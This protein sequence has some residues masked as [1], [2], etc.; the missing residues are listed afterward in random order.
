MTSL[1]LNRELESVRRE[2][3]NWKT[4][5]HENTAGT[6]GD[7]TFAVETLIHERAGHATVDSMC[8]TPVKVRGTSRHPRRAVSEAANFDFAVVKNSQRHSAVKIFLVAG[9]RGEMFARAARRKGANIVDLELT[10]K[11][12]QKRYGNILF[13]CDLEE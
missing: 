3:R 2:L 6:H 1:K 8:E 11:V 12:F 13:Y 10:L 5:Q 4:G 9:P 7:A